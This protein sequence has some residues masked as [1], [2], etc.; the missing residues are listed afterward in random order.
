MRVNEQRR[1]LDIARLIKHKQTLV[2]IFGDFKNFYPELASALLSVFVAQHHDLLGRKVA[3]AFL[4]SA[5]IL[6]DFQP[7]FLGGG[8]FGMGGCRA[9]TGQND[10]TTREKRQHWSCGNHE[11]LRSMAISSVGR[12]KKSA[13]SAKRIVIVTK[14]PSA[15]LTSNPD[16]ANT[17][18]PADKTALVVHNAWPTVRKAERTASGAGRPSRRAFR[19][20]LRK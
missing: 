16:V 1:S 2:T 17:R 10:Q 11:F 20:L 19:Y 7:G 14:S 4:A 12:S 9:K 18:K 8:I 3:K 6:G 15:Q 5:G 13:A